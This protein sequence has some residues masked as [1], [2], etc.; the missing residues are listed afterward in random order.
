MALL[1]RLTFD[2]LIDT[3]NPCDSAS[4]GKF[5]NAKI[6]NK[7][8]VDQKYKPH[9]YVVDKESTLYIVTRSTSS[10]EDWLTNFEAT[11]VQ[12]QFGSTTTRCHKGFYRSAQYVYNISKDYMS[13]YTGK[14]VITGHSLG[15]AITSIVTHMALT[16]PDLADKD[17][18]GIAYAPPPAMEY[19]PPNIRSKLAAFMNSDDIVPRLSY[20]N[21][22]ATYY[23]QI[24]IGGSEFLSK[25]KNDFPMLS[26]LT[27]NMK[28]KLNT[29]VYQYYLNRDLFHVHYPWGTLFHLKGLYQTLNDT[30][31]DPVSIDRLEIS[32]NATLDHY[33]SKYQENIEILFKDKPN[34]QSKGKDKDLTITLSITVPIIILLLVIV[35]VLLVLLIS[36]NRKIENIEK[37]LITSDV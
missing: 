10:K 15:G 32:D 9:F 35:I 2:F 19:V 11:E 5:V 24:S 13:N 33:L 16:D 23:D 25:I 22:L 29:T 26:F 14:I 31:I 28:Q 30:Q 27:T 1:N 3:I 18:I 7:S 36:R 12:C 21:I 6:L 37:E 8:T 4:H 17:I 20:P 34:E